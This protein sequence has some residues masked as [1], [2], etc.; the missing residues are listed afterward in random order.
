MG[1]WWLMAVLSWNVVAD[2]R[3]SLRDEYSLDVWQVED[4]LPDN[5]VNSIVQTSDGYLWFGTFNGLVR[6]DGLRFQRMDLGVAGLGSGRV[7]QLYLDRQGAL[8][9]AMEYG[10]IARYSR[11]KFTVLGVENGWSGARARFFSEDEM[12]RLL[13]SSVEGGLFRFDGQRF[14]RL[15]PDETGP[16]IYGSNLFGHLASR[17]LVR[18]GDYLGTPGRRPVVTPHEARRK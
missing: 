1:C 11:G 3:V 17:A 4:G 7:V 16:A 10:Q 6:F 9:I 13:V 12:G 18:R 5:S 15:L 2:E 8:W 14:Q